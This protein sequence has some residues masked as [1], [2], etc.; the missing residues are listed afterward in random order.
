MTADISEIRLDESARP[1][2]TSREAQEAGVAIFDLTEESH[3]AVPGGPA[4]PYAMT[5]GR[6]DAGVRFVLATA[7]GAT[8]AAFMLPAA[9]LA[10]PAKDYADICASYV[11]AVK[12]LPPARIEALD[13][14]RRDIHTAGAQRVLE[15]LDASVTTDLATARRLFTLFCA[16]HA[17]DIPAARAS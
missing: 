14:A 17:A 15:L 4:G 1:E 13:A 2:A 3:L 8:A 12:S 9:A 5:V 11:A 16:I 10:Q 6:D 7:G